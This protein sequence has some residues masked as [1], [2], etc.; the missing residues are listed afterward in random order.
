[1][2]KEMFWNCNRGIQPARERVDF[3]KESLHFTGKYSPRN[4]LLLLEMDAFAEFERDL[5]SA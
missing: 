2:L 3:V 4:T 5:T 1:M